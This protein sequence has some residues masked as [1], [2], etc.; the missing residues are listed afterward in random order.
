MSA[1]LWGAAVGAL[2]GAGL[3]MILGV[4][5]RRHPTAVE[6]EN[7]CYGWRIARTIGRLD[8]GQCVVVR[9]TMVM[10]VECLEGTDET[11]R[12]GAAL[13]GKG[14]VAIKILKPGQDKRLDQPALGLTTI[15]VLVENGFTCLAYEADG[16]L[17]FD[18]DECVALADK[19]NICL[20]GLNHAAVLERSL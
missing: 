6:W 3:V 16:A 8:I 18:R 7:I 19:H 1:G 14:C 17:L 5:T 11:L 20:I 2:G 12:R 9:R 10:A 4:L 13:G 15:K